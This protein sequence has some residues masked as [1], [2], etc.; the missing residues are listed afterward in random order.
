MKN[1]L[2]IAIGVVTLV[3]LAACSG[4]ESG[5]LK[6][7]F[8]GP[9]TG[10]AAALGIDMLNGMKLAVQEINANGGMNGHVVEIIAEDGRCTPAEAVNGFQKLVNVDHVSGIIG[11]LC[12]GETLAGAPIAEA[13]KVVM[14]SPGSSSPKIT[15]AG[16]YVYRNYPSDAFKGV[17]M[18]KYFKQKGYA[19]VAIITHNTDYATGLRDAIV[20]NVG[21]ENV[22]FN[23]TVEET[24]KDFRSLLSRLRKMDFDVFVPNMQTDGA[25]G[26][27]V[28]QYRE[29]EL[30][31][32][33]VGTDTTDS[34]AV[35]EIAGDAAEGVQLVNVPSAGEGTSFEQKFVAA[36]Q[37]PQ[38]S[39]SW[40]AY[41]YDA[42]G[43]LLEALAKGEGDP[44]KVKA[45]L[46]LHPGY[47]GVIGTFRFDE[48]GDVVGAT[49]V[50]KEFKDGAIV[51]VGDITLD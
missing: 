24:T 4:G 22:V 51:T 6:I 31:A 36:F 2:R 12:S 35:A 43:I 25:A 18:A 19:K 29:Q 39:I 10:D 45:H 15:T 13:A 48:N 14:I 23:E 17:A 27:L 20:Q 37:K 5:P 42:T 49:Y 9:L 41:S 50:V 47:A 32:P 44:E 28:A 3:S 38:S 46:D 30:T 34:L 11:G 7:G 1:T 40:A 21:A 26:A 16:T 8:V 33:I